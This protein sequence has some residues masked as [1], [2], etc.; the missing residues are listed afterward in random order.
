MRIR[1]RG[2]RRR[3]ETYPSSDEAL[4]TLNRSSFLS[5]ATY[6]SSTRRR[7]CNEVAQSHCSCTADLAFEASSW[8]LRCLLPFVCP[9][10]GSWWSYLEPVCDLGVYSAN[11]LQTFADNL[12]C[13]GGLQICL[14]RDGRDSLANVHSCRYKL[15]RGQVVVGPRCVTRTSPSLSGQG[16]SQANWLQAH[17]PIG[18]AYQHS[19]VLGSLK[20]VHCERSRILWLAQTLC[21]LFQGEAMQFIG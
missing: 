2:H 21:E 9:Q 6:C 4:G 19:R 10:F 16:G 3:R 12:V 20:V 8:F 14:R 17:G 1:N 11:P 5:P 7:S 18:Q 13:L 15:A